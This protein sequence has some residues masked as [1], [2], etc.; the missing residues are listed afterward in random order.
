MVL[1][2]AVGCG[3]AGMFT[4]SDSELGSSRLCFSTK[5]FKGVDLYRIIIIWG[6]RRGRNWEAVLCIYIGWVIDMVG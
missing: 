4:Y 5:S 6:I 1:S 2:L 3:R